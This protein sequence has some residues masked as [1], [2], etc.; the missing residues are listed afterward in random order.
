MIKV[1]FLKTLTLLYVEDDEQVRAKFVMILNKLFKKVLVAH[2]GIDGLQKFHQANKNAIYIDLIIS[3]IA[4]PKMDGVEFLTHI[5][6]IDPHIPFMF[7]TAYTNSEFLIS[8]IQ[9]GVTDYFVKPVDAKEIISQVQKTCELKQ[10][11]KELNHYQNEIEKY[12]DVIN[13]VAVV[14]IFDLKGELT[15]VNEFFKEVSGYTEEELLGKNYKFI[16]HSDMSQEI[17]KK[18]WEMLQNGKVWNGKVKHLS[19]D[20]EN[21]YTNTTIMPMYCKD[22][23]NEVKYIS[24]KF[25]TTKEENEKRE[26]KRRVLFNL[27]ETKKI[28]QGAKEKILGLNKKIEGYK[29]FDKIEDQL[30]DQKKISNKH[31]SKI[32]ELEHQLVGVQQEYEDMTTSAN[33]QIRDALGVA[34]KMKAK[35]ESAN[36]SSSYIKSE[37]EIREELILRLKVQIDTQ[38]K[39]ISDLEDVVKHRE[40]QLEMNT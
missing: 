30:E 29:A 10:K 6:K 26:Y 31:Y 40:N 27:Q 3:D 14:S 33:G 13:K 5:R 21:F 16:A 37:I 7:T 15:Y 24:I 19:K 9:Q 25:I 32:K 36:Q 34:T 11:E 18:Q 1:D 23:L 20:G 12:M 4:M 8:S 22:A 38:S 28:N 2:D 39:K 35:K 17:F